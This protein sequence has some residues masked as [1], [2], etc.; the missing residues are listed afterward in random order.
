[1]GSITV[2]LTIPLLMGTY[3]VAKFSSKDLML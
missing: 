1:M 3:I 2:D